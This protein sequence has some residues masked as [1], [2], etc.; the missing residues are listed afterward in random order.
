[1]VFLLAA[2]EEL[3]PMLL[4]CL[5]HNGR[6]VPVCL[7]SV[8]ISLLIIQTNEVVYSKGQKDSLFLFHNYD[9]FCRVSSPVRLGG[10]CEFAGLFIPCQWQNFAWNWTLYDC[11]N[12]EP[13]DFHSFNKDVGIL[14]LDLSQIGIAHHDGSSSAL[15]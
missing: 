2:P 5:F 9:M 6:C 12:S 13:D 14:Y 8:L 4:L 7:L 3:S 15:F 10:A 1:M 11:V